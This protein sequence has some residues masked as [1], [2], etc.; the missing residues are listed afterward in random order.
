M[1]HQL[2]QAAADAAGYLYDPT[3]HDPRGLWIVRPGSQRQEDQ[4]LWNPLESGADSENL[5]ILFGLIVWPPTPDYPYVVAQNADSSIEAV[6]PAY[7]DKRGAAR[8]A[9]VDAVIKMKRKP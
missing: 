1:T 3:R 6:R 4:V 2:L 8:R 7:R 5:R 9:I